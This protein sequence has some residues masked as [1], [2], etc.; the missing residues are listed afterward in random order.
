MLLPTL[1]GFEILD[2]LLG[3]LVGLGEVVE[4]RQALV[5][6]LK[7]ARSNIVDLTVLLTTSLH[8]L[9]RLMRVSPSITPPAVNS[10]SARTC[11]VPTT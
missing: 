8:P 10:N 6:K 4:M 5:L 1:A 9:G 2:D 7:G 11:R 3:E